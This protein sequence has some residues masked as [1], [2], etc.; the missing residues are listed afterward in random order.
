M[1][2]TTDAKK[3]KWPD[4]VV[5]T[6]PEWKRQTKTMEPIG[7]TKGSMDYVTEVVLLCG[8]WVSI[9]FQWVHQ[10]YC[11]KTFT[12]YRQSKISQKYCDITL[13]ALKLFYTLYGLGERISSVW[14]KFWFKIRRDHGKKFLWARGL[15]VGRR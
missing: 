13:K 10:C 8:C 6:T 3:V 7:S 4:S 11:K 14:P 12:N 9:V 15:W 2:V 1:T 5:F